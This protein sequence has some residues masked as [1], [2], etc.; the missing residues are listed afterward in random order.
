MPYMTPA[1]SDQPAFI[2][3]LLDLSGSMGLPCGGRRRIDVVANALERTRRKMIARSRRGD[4]VRPR[5]AVAMLGYSNTAVDLLGGIKTIDQLE[6]MRLPDLN[7]QGGTNTASAFEAAY[8]LLQQY[9]PN[10]HDCPAPLV[11][12]LTDGAANPGDRSGPVAEGI[13]QLANAD[14]TVL[15][16]NIYIGDQLLRHPIT[17]PKNW[18]GVLNPGDILEEHVQSLWHM[19]SPLPESYA[20]EMNE[21]EGYRMQPGAKM[22]IP[23][24]APE[25]IEL[26]FAMSS[27]TPRG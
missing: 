14:G 19:S 22:L 25:M 21:T 7:P 8:H 5:Y 18:P 15:V 27:A 20:A 24:E 11:C 10:L 4:D 2:I 26:A 3:Y 9:L 6:T 17:D 23:A 12:H 1:T 13:K 16:E